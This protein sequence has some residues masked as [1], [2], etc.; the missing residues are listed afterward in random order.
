VPLKDTP[1]IGQRC[2]GKR[3][4]GAPTDID[5]VQKGA[6]RLPT[7]QAVIAKHDAAI[8]MSADNSAIR[9]NGPIAATPDAGHPAAHMQPAI[10][11]STERRIEFESRHG[12]LAL[13]RGVSGGLLLYTVHSISG[14][15]RW[16][17]SAL[18]LL[19]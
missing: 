4:R 18:V 8:A 16:E 6:H 2:V 7:L 5:V 3:L 1:D 15:F 19:C 10:G 9:K 11:V 12:S 13:K 14:K 17:W